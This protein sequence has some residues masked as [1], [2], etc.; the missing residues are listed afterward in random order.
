MA[1]QLQILSDLHLEAPAA[2]DVYKI[3]PRAPYLALLG[4]IGDSRSVG[5]IDFIAQQL[6]KFQIVFFVLGN[7]EPYHGSWS[8]VKARLK[9]FA[10]GIAQRRKKEKSLGQFVFVDQTRFDISDTVTVLGCILY[11]YILDE[12]LEHVSFGLNDFYHIED[13]DVHLHRQA[14]QSDL[15]WLND[16]VRQI[17]ES[18][19]QRK[20]VILS[21]H[22]PVFGGQAT[23]PKHAKSLL[24]SGFSTDLSAEE[25]W[26]N[27]NVKVWAFGHSHFNCDYK[28]EMTGKRVMT[29]QRGYYFAKS[30][31]FDVEKIVTV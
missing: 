27:S 16:Q 31:G 4:D 22:S 5:L 6:T 23:D 20:I 13:W 29:N 15:Q 10:D 19:P 21:H 24:S 18:E 11:S 28:D 26:T 25:C 17:S 3:P 8:A 12:Q 2:Y 7:H 1:V 14:H 30:P 9:A